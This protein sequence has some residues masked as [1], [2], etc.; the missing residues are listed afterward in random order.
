[1]DLM[2]YLVIVGF[3]LGAGLLVLGLLGRAAPE[4][5]AQGEAESEQ[6]SAEGVSAQLRHGFERTGRGAA[7]P[8]AQDRARRQQESLALLTAFVNRFIPGTE[9][10]R[11][12]DRDWLV[13][14]GLKIPP[15]TF[16]AF[17]VLCSLAGVLVG[18][19]G[20]T[21]MDGLGSSVAMVLLCLIVGSQVPTFYVFSRRAKWRAELDRALPDALDLMTV[22][23]S[24]GTTLE[25]SLRIVSERMDGALA[26]A[27]ADIVEESRYGSR[28]TA[29]VEFARRS[30]VSSFQTFAASLAQAEAAGAPLL[31]VLKEQA[32]N[33]RVLRRLELEQKANELQIKVMLPMIGC[34]FPVLIIMLVAPLVPLLMGMLG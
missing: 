6:D 23:V 11:A 26:Q 24:A 34:I 19:Y 10:D 7:R 2:V 32:S 20:A 30:G 12:A 22:A 3:S 31:D 9:E 29:L 16:W 5:R 21:F 25:S 1:M 27:F 14:S 28:G 15:Q 13:H 17:R 33:A 8:S 18:V 4:A